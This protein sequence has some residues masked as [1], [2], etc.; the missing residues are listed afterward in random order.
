MTDDIYPELPYV[1]G[2]VRIYFYY[3]HLH[4]LVFIYLNLHLIA[5][6]N[7]ICYMFKPHTVPTRK[8]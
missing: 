8:G 5:S 2:T 3:I 1:T 4:L 6:Q 7:Y